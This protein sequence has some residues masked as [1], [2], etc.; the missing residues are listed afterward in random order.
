M[1]PLDVVKKHKFTYVDY[2]Q[3]MNSS[4]EVKRAIKLLENDKLVF[5][6]AEK[7]LLLSSHLKPKGFHELRCI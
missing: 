2:L 5:S 6:R 1:F 4:G 3:V 7:Y